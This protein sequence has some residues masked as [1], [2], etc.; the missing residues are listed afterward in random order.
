MNDLGAFPA[1][2][3]DVLRLPDHDADA[4][5]TYL[6]FY[7]QMKQEYGFARHCL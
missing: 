4:G 5:I 1:A 2:A 6:G 7:N 3:Q